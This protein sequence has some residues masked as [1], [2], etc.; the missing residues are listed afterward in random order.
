[1]RSREGFEEALDE[2]LEL[3]ARSWPPPTQAK[4]LA[5]AVD[6]DRVAI[7]LEEFGRGVDRH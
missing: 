6:E 2:E 7:H 4:E 1:M 3:L 5:L